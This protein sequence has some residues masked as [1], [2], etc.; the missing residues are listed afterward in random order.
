VAETSAAGTPSEET[1][2]GGNTNVVVRVGDTVRRR[3]G[4]WTP[5]VHALLAHLQSV[6]FADAPTVQ[7]IDGQ[8]REIL[9]FVI[10]EVG[11]F[12]PDQLPPTTRFGDPAVA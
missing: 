11:N 4:H 3:T 1:L 8:G 10:G 12:D 5:A 6:G 9:S 7:G 2:H